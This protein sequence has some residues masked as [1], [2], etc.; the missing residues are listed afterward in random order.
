[1]PRRP[2]ALMLALVVVLALVVACRDAPPHSSGPAA[3]AAA[4]PSAE[5][6]DS[7][8]DSGNRNS[9]DQCAE[10][11]KNVRDG[12]DP[13]GGCFPGPSNTGVPAGTVLSDYTGPCRITTADTVID[14]MTI[15]C[16]P[17]EVVAENVVLKNS[18]VDGGIWVDSPEAGSVTVIDTTIDAGEVSA[19]EDDGARALC[20]ANFTAIRIRATG[21]ISGGF[22]EYYCEVRDSFICCQDR[23][24]SGRAHQS[25]I[26]LGSGTRPN[27]QRLIHNTIRCDGPEVLPDAGCS[28]D[29]TGY[30]D[31]DVIRNNLVERNLLE[32]SPSGAFCAYGGSSLGKPFGSGSNNVWKHNI[33]QRGPSGKC[34]AYGATTDFGAGLR[35][36][37]FENNRWDTGELMPQPD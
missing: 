10:Q 3:P 2:A 37:V 17:L 5:T 26:R 28:A 23:D 34:A 30:G 33:F 7:D 29:V 32:W 31:F 25:G 12:E 19:T 14:E 13:W 11:E 36:N 24:E 21:G 27:S 4:S 35:G 1:M 8:P 9:R 16:H 20:C 6:R 15:D 18:K 22:C